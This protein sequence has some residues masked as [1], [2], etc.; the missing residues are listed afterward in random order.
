MSPLFWITVSGVAL[1]LTTLAGGLVLWLR[2]RMMDRILFPIVGL[3]AGSLLGRA[4]LHLPR[5]GRPGSGFATQRATRDKLETT[6]SLLLE[7][8]ILF[9]ATWID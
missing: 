5:S 8:A 3:T 2:E 1:S 7:L 4:F 6:G 9:T